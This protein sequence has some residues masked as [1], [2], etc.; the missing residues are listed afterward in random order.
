[1]KMYMYWQ[2][3]I[4]MIKNYHCLQYVPKE[5]DSSVQLE[6]AVMILL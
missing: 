2:R 1:M 6:I 5:L 4:I 3:L